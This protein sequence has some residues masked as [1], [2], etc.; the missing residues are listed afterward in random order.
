MSAKDEFH[1][2]AVT[3]RGAVGI[4]RRGNE[5]TLGILCPLIE[6]QPLMPGAELVASV[7]RDN[8]EV[9]DLKTI[10]SVPQK[11]PA[12]VSTPSYRK[13]HDRIFKNTDKTLN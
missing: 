7:K 6:G 13:N 10:Y 2:K 5:E 9:L 8:G 4:R 3:P 12:K 11:G 1:L